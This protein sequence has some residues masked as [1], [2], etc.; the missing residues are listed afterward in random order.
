MRRKSQTE[1]A[2]L[3]NDIAKLKSQKDTQPN[4]IADELR[5]QNAALVA[6]IDDETKKV[7]DA[8]TR[9]EHLEEQ[10][11]LAKAQFSSQAEKLQATNATIKSKMATMEVELARFRRDNIDLSRKL[12]EM[13]TKCKELETKSSQNAVI[14][15]EKNRLLGSLQEKNHQY[16]LLISENEMNKDLSDQLKKEVKKARR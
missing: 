10:H 7:L 9:Y 8:A 5:K 11:V 1:K 15:H 6:R 16:E 12:V 3:E 4:I 2:T 13:Q 14:E